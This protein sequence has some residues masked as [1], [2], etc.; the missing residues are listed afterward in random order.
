MTLALAWLAKRSDGREDLYFASDSRTRGGMVLDVTPKILTLPRSDCAICFAG[1]TAATFPLMLHISA[2]IA[3]HAPAQDRNLDIGEL[4]GHLL[5]V[6]TDIMRSVVDRPLPLHPTDVQFIFGGYSW[7]AKDFSLWTIYYETQ[8][9]KFRARTADA[10]HRRLR[11]AAFIGDWATRFRTA[12][13]KELNADREGGPI[14]HEPL[15][16]LSRFL[17]QAKGGDSI[18]GA[19][20]VVRVGPHMN[21]RPF[22]VTWGDEQKPYLFGRMLFEYENCDFWIIDPDSGRI[23]APRHFKLDK[24]ADLEH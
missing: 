13:V 11:K 10:F 23:K 8:S 6:C 22:C 15:T 24:K 7:R 19:P 16:L 12:L 20:Q 1:D 18:G 4:K 21:T 14:Q 5:K 3:A 2:A 17:K 9:K